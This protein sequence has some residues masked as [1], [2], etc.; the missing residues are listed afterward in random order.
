[1]TLL[2]W[3]IGDVEITRVEERV[4]PLPCE[5]L[6]PGI[7]AEHIAANADWCN[8]FFTDS[9]KILLSLHS[10]IVR[11]GDTT[12]VVDTC[13]GTR[14]PRPL[15]G[16]DTFL[17]RLD[18]AI[19]GGLDAV[20][21]VVCTHLHFDHVGWNT[22][23]RDGVVV[24]TFPAARYLVTAAELDHLAIDDHNEVI[25][26]SVQP[27]VTAGVLDAVGTDHV[28][29]DA[30]RLIA[31]P[32]HTPGHVSVL[33][34]SQGQTGLITGDATHNP[35][36]FTYPE[37]AA[38]PFDHDSMQSTATRATLVERYGNGDTLMLGTH[39]APPTAGHIRI[40]NG[41]TWFD[42]SARDTP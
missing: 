40:A 17:D 9:G 25:E 22:T 11:S 42:I 3:T 16:D 20:D 37:L 24:P 4:V 7:T 35:L 14:T 15:P 10:F 19:V 31:T 8:P 5:V 30:V 12:I 36:Q 2:R 6:I 38:T 26:P 29:T 33:I 28:I 1:M 13:V 34:E 27:L 18:D 23:V 32:G 41:R 39:F 21:V